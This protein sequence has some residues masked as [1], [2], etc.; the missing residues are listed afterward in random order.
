MI[1]QAKTSRSLSWVG[2]LVVFGMG[3]SLLP[4]LPVQAQQIPTRPSVQG[5]EPKDPLDQQI[6]A[7]RQTIQ[8]LEARKQAEKKA[9]AADAGW[10]VVR[11]GDPVK[12][13]DTLK[14]ITAPADVNFVRTRR[15]LNLQEA[16]EVEQQA[17]QRQQEQERA[18]HDLEKAKR[19]Y[20]L[21]VTSAGSPELQKARAEAQALAQQIGT[22]S[23]ELKELEARQEVVMAQLKKMEAE[24]ALAGQTRYRVNLLQKKAVTDAKSSDLEQKLDR[25]LKEVEELRREIRPQKTPNPMGDFFVPPA[26]VPSTPAV[27]QPP[28]KPSTP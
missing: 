15:I 28:I 18:Q 12:P 27:P 20:E 4:L 3:L 8:A 1:M 9:A 5:T 26:K 25:L 21:A 24:A 6:E 16:R 11:P 22:K 19:L 23:R 14:V 13:G 7:L 10:T 17:A 2:C